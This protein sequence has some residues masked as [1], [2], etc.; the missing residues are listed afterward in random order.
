MVATK[1]NLSNARMALRTLSLPLATT[2]YI[3][4]N[5]T[6]LYHSAQV[7]FRLIRCLSS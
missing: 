7:K 1:C 5:R 2:D 3:E 4:V 6:L